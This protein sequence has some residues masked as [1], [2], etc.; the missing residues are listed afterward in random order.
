MLIGRGKGYRALSD[1]TRSA[2]PHLAGHTPLIEVGYCANAD[3]SLYTASSAP[4]ETLFAF[5]RN[6]RVL[7]SRTP[8]D[9]KNADGFIPS[10]FLNTTYRRTNKDE[11]STNV[12]SQKYL[13]LERGTAI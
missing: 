5:N 2:C 3:P 7:S 8:D 10:R 11:Y 1:A 9:R 13:V 4:Q 12:A 6:S